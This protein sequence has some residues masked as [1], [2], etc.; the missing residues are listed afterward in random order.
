M[1][2]EKTVTKAN[3]NIIYEI[4]NKPAWNFFKE[5]LGDE[6]NDISTEISPSVSIGVALPLEMT[7]EYEGRA[8]I[9]KCDVDSSPSVA[10]RFSIRNIPTALFFK[11][12]EVADKQV[13][14]VPKANFVSKLEALI[15]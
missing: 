3:G 1:G 10:A 15:D 4:E 2:I 8:L 7:T 14:A 6:I 9:V 11:G 12:G 5:Y 13:G